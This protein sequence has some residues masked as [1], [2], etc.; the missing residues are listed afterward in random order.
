MEFTLPCPQASTLEP[1]Y[2]GL[3]AIATRNWIPNSQRNTVTKKIVTL[4]RKICD[5]LYNQNHEIVLATEK[6]ERKP[7]ELKYSYKWL[8]GKHQVALP[9]AVPDVVA[10]P[11]G[12]G[13]KEDI[14]SPTS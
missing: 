3:F 1:T 9:E 5:I 7:I 8:E 6:Y 12:V 2:A 14:S 11:V 13:T 10:Q 4:L